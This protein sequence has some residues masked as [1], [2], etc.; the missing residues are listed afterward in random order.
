MLMWLF[1]TFSVFLFSSTAPAGWAAD[2]STALDVQSTVG[3]VNISS[4][5]VHDGVGD[6]AFNSQ[7]S[8]TFFPA[9]EASDANVHGGTS[10]TLLSTMAA[11]QNVPLMISPMKAV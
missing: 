3:N 7:N 11:G 10:S 5:I 9:P 2:Q 1:R 4:A 6:C 8:L